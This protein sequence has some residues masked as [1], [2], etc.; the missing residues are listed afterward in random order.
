MSTSGVNTVIQYFYSYT[1]FKVIKIMPVFPCSVQYVL[2]AY[3]RY[4]QWFVSLNPVTL[5]CYL[6]FF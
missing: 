4:T 3:L 1:T 2:A 6:T 5:S